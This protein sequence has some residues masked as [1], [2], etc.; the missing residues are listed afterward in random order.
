[1]QQ[2]CIRLKTNEEVA[3]LDAAT[4]PPPVYLNW[5]IEKLRDAAVNDALRR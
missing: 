4:P 5:F 1:M 3:Q 2:N